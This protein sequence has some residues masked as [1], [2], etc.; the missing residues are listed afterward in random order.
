MVVDTVTGAAVATLPIGR[1]TDAAAFDPV[2]KLI[3]SSNGLDG[4]VSVIR[5]VDARTFVPAGTIKTQLSARTMSV[6]PATG[7]LFLLAAETNPAAMAAFLAAREA[8]RHAPSPFAPGT[9]KL[10]FFDPAP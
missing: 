2:R 9:L 6:D 8:G 1:G 3:F 10:L 5:E 4:T 7:R